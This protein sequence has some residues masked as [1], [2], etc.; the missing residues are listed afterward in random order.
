MRRKILIQAQ[1]QEVGLDELSVPELK[2]L[3]KRYGLDGYSDLKKDGLIEL[4][5]GKQEELTA[6]RQPEPVLAQ[7]P[8]AG[9]PD[10]AAGAPPGSTGDPFAGG[11]TISQ[12]EE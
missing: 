3:A 12:E 4:I 6:Y 2:E 1:N 10:P 9:V 5:A 7:G 8:G 11:T